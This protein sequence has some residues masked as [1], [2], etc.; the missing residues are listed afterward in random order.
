VTVSAA[1]IPRFARRA[2]G[3]SA[4]PWFAYAL[5]RL[6][7]LLLVLIG[8]LFATFIMI[9]LVP[10]DPAQIMLGDLADAENVANLREKLGLDQ[11]WPQQFVSYVVSLLRGDMGT[12]Y[13]TRQP[14]ATVIALRVADSAQLAAS[15]LAL[16]M[17]A[18]VPV[19]MVAGAF[20]REGRHKRFEVAF[21]ALT[22][23]IGSIPEYLLGTFLAFFFAVWLRVLPVA[24]NEG[25][26]A[27]ILPT[28]AIALRPIAVLAR[29][30]RLETLNV[31]STDYIRTAHMKRLRN[32]TIYFR[33][34]LP[35][36]LTAALTIG[37][38]LFA[39]VIGGAVI[40]EAVFARPGMGTA[41]VNSIN[42]RDYPV[43]Q[44]IVLVLGTT[45]VLVNTAVDLILAAIDPRSMARQS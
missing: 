25:P 20:T 28:L 27:L 5:R 43:V 35:N 45:V 12:S 38:L 22:S 1:G 16:V 29:I 40:V 44:G 11:P 6:L 24:G 41:L 15:A 18:C 23:V 10:G 32:R 3:L 30:V 31:L 13:L 34:V 33:H 17:I 8:L 2:S 4:N 37:G 14:V 39:G 36:V 19:G 42:A 26:Q 7:G 21:T 9:R